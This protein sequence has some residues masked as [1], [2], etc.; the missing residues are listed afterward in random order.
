MEFKDYYDILGVAPDADSQSIKKAYRKKARQYHPDVSQHRNAE[1]KFKEA[2]EAYE[3]LKDREKRAKY[4]ALKQYGARGQ[5]FNPPPGWDSETSY[6][7]KHSAQFNKDFS[8]F[9]SNLYGGSSSNRS[10][11]PFETQYEFQQRGQDIETDMPLFLEETLVTTTKPISYHLDGKNKTLQVKIPAGTA[12]GDRIRLKGQGGS[13]Y[14]GAENG[15]LYLRIKWVPHPLFDVEY[16]DLILTLALTPWEAALG[17]K[18]EIPTL[19]NNIQLSIPANSQTGQRLRIRGQGL[20]SKIGNGDLYAV[21]KVVMPTSTNDTTKRLW[22][23]LS[24]AEN[25]DPRTEWRKSS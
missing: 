15:D 21:L 9:F 24:E 8:D 18:I 1:E 2:S 25:F 14:A 10:E 19:R 17:T 12:N 6:N 20:N 23:E 11:T 4:D 22:Q 7:E 5:D 16:H 3:V 13:G